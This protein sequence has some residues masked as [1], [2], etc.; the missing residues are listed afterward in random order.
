MDVQT[1]K[2]NCSALFNE[3]KASLA[4]PEESRFEEI[5]SMGIN[6]MSLAV[7]LGENRKMFY[8]YS[9]FRIYV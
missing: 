4:L 2:I 6:C 5:F 8:G 3:E 9:M 7:W 1:I